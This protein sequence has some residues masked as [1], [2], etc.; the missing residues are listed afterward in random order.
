VTDAF[1]AALCTLA[2]L[3]P[4]AEERPCDHCR[5]LTRDELLVEADVRLWPMSELCEE[6]DE[7]LR[8]DLEDEFL[9]ERELR[10]REAAVRIGG[11][12]WLEEP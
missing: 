10:R 3:P 5:V 12:G 2:E 9:S 6:C 7:M 4:H 11:G 1:I 8:S